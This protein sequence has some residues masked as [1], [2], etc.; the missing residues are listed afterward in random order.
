M[1]CAGEYNL[2][3]LL[4]TWWTFSKIHII[5]K[6]FSRRQQVMPTLASPVICWLNDVCCK[7][8][9]MVLPQRRTL[10]PCPPHSCCVVLPLSYWS[11]VRSS[12]FKTLL[13]IYAFIC[14]LDHSGNADGLASNKGWEIFN[15][16]S[17]RKFR[18]FLPDGIVPSKQALEASKENHLWKRKALNWS[19]SHQKAPNLPD[20]F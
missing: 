16:C 9:H 13:F 12:A 19:T 1:G 10:N 7:G 5:G 18:Q 20:R 11:S 6:N 17:Q 3:T 14:E 4:Y 2:S 8:G 15:S